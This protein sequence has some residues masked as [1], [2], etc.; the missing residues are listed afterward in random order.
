M[1]LFIAIQ[2]TDEMKNALTGVQTF[3]RGHGV[4]GNFTRLDN[5][6]LTLAFIGEYADPD[7][8]LDAMRSV[9]FSTFSIRLDGFGSFR[10]LYWSGIGGSEELAACVKGRLPNRAFPLTGRNFLR[11]SPCC[12]R[13]PLTNAPLSPA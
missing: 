3:L 7:R 6:H 2:L 4:H 5:L 10:D 1:R 12:A 9:A 13:R 11:I 8:V